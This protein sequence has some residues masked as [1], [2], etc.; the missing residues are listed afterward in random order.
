VVSISVLLQSVTCATEGPSDPFVCICHVSRDFFSNGTTS[1]VTWSSYN[2]TFP[3]TQ[4]FFS[5]T[6]DFEGSLGGVS[7]TFLNGT[8]T[9]GLLTNGSTSF[10]LGPCTNPTIIDT[11]VFYYPKRQKQGQKIGSGNET[12]YYINTDLQPNATQYV[13]LIPGQ[14]T[15]SSLTLTDS[16]N[17]SVFGLSLKVEFDLA[18]FALDE[19]FDSIIVGNSVFCPELTF[20]N[21]QNK[22]WYNITNSFKRSGDI[23]GI[24]ETGPIGLFPSIPQIIYLAYRTRQDAVSIIAPP[25]SNSCSQGT[26]VG[27]SDFG[28]QG[29]L[30]VAVRVEIIPEVEPQLQVVEIVLAVFFVILS[31]L[32]AVVT[33]VCSR[34]MTK[35][36]LYHPVLGNE[37]YNSS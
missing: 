24:M 25:N 22:T 13:V 27:V 34:K 17:S 33:A 5:Y 12:A 16:Y 8:N 26:T 21:L 1:F 6:L 23:D 10:S 31:V 36:D 28:V 15:F 11:S 3:S 7:G 35:D 37:D 2:P 9:V 30:K 19:I 29:G 4:G 20:D 14:Y 32:S 18:E